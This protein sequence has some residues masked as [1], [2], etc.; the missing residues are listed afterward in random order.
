MSLTREQIFNHLH[1]VHQHESGWQDSWEILRKA[2]G[3][4]VHCLLEVLEVEMTKAKQ[5]TL[6]VPVVSYK[7]LLRLAELLAEFND[8]RSLWPLLQVSQLTSIVNRQGSDYLGNVLEVMARRAETEDIQALI[9]ELMRA[10]PQWKIISSSEVMAQDITDVAKALIRVAERDPKPELR[11]A[12]PFLKPSL[13]TPVSFIA[14]HRRLKAA[15]ASASLSI[16]VTVS[17][18]T[19]GLPIPVE[20]VA[21]E[22]DPE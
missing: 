4:V 14:L 1:A 9:F 16:P 22:H 20:E 3:E 13:Q 19:E 11:A 21:F 18:R 12:L 10:R 2:S 8:P 15:L 5:G 7:N 17:Q 6:V